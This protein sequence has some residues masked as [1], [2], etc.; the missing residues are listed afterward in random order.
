MCIGDILVKCQNAISN[1]CW[2]DCGSILVAAGRTV[3]IYEKWIENLRDGKK[4]E[5]LF[6]LTKQVDVPVPKNIFNSMLRFNG[7]LPEYHP[8]LIVEYLL[9]GNLCLAKNTLFTLYRFVRLAVESGKEILEI[10]DIP[11]PLLQILEEEDDAMARPHDKKAQY[12]ALFDSRRVCEEEK[13]YFFCAL[14]F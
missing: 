13:E 1:I 10:S 9:W 12:D 6:L 2:L 7:R 3:R 5:A 11:V 8:R 4:V 14:S